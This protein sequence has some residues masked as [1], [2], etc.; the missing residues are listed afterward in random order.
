MPF[1]KHKRLMSND[2]SEKNIDKENQQLNQSTAVYDDGGENPKR[3]RYLQEEQP[4]I[5]HFTWLALYVLPDQVGQLVC[6][7]AGRGWLGTQCRRQSASF[8]R[9]APSASR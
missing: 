3:R 9:S 2:E 1:T 4:V 8:V 5:E 7:L 6:I